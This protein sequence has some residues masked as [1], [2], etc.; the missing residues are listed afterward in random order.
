MSISDLSIDYEPTVREVLA[1]PAL[2]RG[3]PRVLAGQAGLDRRV[4]W[5]HVSEPHDSAG[6]L[7]GG[8]LILTTGSGLSLS[9][10][11]LQTY[12]HDL[13]CAN[14]AGLVIELGRHFHTAPA[15]LVSAAERTHLPLIS[16]ENAVRFVEV[17]REVH[18][19]IAEQLELLQISERAHRVFTRLGM[20]DVLPAEIVR[21]AGAAIDCTVVFESL[22]HNIL[23]LDARR[24]SA[25]ELLATWQCQSRRVARKPG[26]F[27]SPQSGF[28]VTEVAIRGQAFGRLIALVGQHTRPAQAMILERAATALTMNQLLEHNRESMERQAHNSVLI[29][30]IEQRY[31]SKSDMMT[32]LATLGMHT[33]GRELIA[34]VVDTRRGS[35][36]AGMHETTIEQVAVAARS[37]KLPNIVAALQ[38]GR[39]AI[40]FATHRGRRRGDVVRG[41]AEEIHGRFGPEREVTIAAGPAVT[42]L[43]SVAHAFVEAC[44]VAEA[45]HG[46]C[47]RKPFFEV[48]DI[49]LRGL[50]YMLGHDAR[51]QAF[52]ERSLGPILLYDDGHG[53]KLFAAVVALLSHSGNKAA[54]AAES[55]VSRQ[56]FYRRIQTA[57]RVLN[58]DLAS[59]ETR[60]SLH[61]AVLAHEALRQR[62]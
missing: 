48:S 51:V 35:S 28:L 39:A 43:D 2:A 26:T 61:A 57:E 55:G 6:L 8:G 33:A 56:A 4:R 19:V 40:L 50:L 60:T 18:Q 5:V 11:D 16:L 47:N 42:D 10:E 29:D 12:V 1:T 14:A 17:T 62:N 38:S 31:T 54:A 23:A 13:A 3:K 32:R 9:P 34:I 46:L 53:T 44:Q 21:Q 52:I 25:T 41:F 24:I 30:L 15:A 27:H 58:V 37:T 36:S 20:Q 7:L 45:A 59:A 22:L 49:G